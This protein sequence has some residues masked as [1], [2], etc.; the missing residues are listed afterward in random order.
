MNIGFFNRYAWLSLILVCL[1]YALVGWYLS[2]H[3]IVWFMGC[4]IAFVALYIASKS[5]PLVERLIGFSSQE[6]LIALF[7]SLTVSAIIVLT[8]TWSMLWTLVLIP[9]ST[10][11]LAELEMRFIGFDQTDTFWILTASAIF[12]LLV[13]EFTDIMFLPSSRY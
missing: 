9:I 5:N 2:A 12:G 4:F 10:T 1:A 13:G 11:F 7:I 8:A 6:L 3:H